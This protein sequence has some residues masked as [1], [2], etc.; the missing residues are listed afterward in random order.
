[1]IRCALSSVTPNRPS[2]RTSSMCPSRVSSASL[3]MGILLND[4]PERQPGKLR[5]DP[6]AALLAGDGQVE[7][8]SAQ[9]GVV[10]VE[11]GDRT[12][13]AEQLERQPRDIALP[14]CLASGR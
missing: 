5:L 3:A 8:A 14:T 11:E 4:R 12:L 7:R 9:G 2:G 13:A 6:G 10:R 1:M